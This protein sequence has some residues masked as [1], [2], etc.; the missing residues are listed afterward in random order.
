VAVANKGIDAHLSRR[1][2]I[3]VVPNADTLRRAVL[4]EL[5]GRRKDTPGPC[6]LILTG[7]H[8]L[9]TA[10][11]AAALDTLVYIWREMDGR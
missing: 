4:Q 9:P 6:P 11:A 1:S 10:L 2:S 7:A 8:R 3:L 5:V